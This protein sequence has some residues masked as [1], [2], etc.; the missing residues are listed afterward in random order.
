MAGL[1][2]T[3]SNM[4]E[5]L[6]ARL[7]DVISTPLTSP[8]SPE[9]V[10]INSR[11]MER[12]LSMQLADHHGICANMSFQFPRPFLLDLL[13][14]MAGAPGTPDLYHPDCLTWK[15]MKLL[16]DISSQP[17]FESIRHYL[18][19]D[20][21]GT[22]RKCYQISRRIARAFDQYL[23][24]RP[25]MI[26]NWESGR[27]HHEDETWQA[28]LWNALSADMAALHPVAL[29]ELFK[30]RIQGSDQ[31]IVSLPER[32]SLIGISALAPLFIDVLLGLSTRTDIHLFLFNPC[33]EYWSEVLSER[34]RERR[35]KHLQLSTDVPLTEVEE[36]LFLEKG[37]P[38]LASMG[39]IS[40]DFLF[41]LA[42]VPSQHQDFF[43]RPGETTLL[44]TVQSDILDLIDRSKGEAERLPL[45]ESDRSIECHS[46]HSPLREVE[47]LHDRLL[48]LFESIPQLKPR[49]ILVMTPDIDTYAPLI[50]SVF[51]RTDEETQKGIR[52]FIPF[53][54]ADR[55]HMRNNPVADT[56][57]EILD[58]AESRFEA[59]RVLTLLDSPMIRRAFFLSEEEIVLIR[60]WVEETGIRWGI[61]DRSLLDLELPLLS[62]HTWRHGID[63]MLLGYALPGE[64][65]RLFE[66]RLPYDG[67]EGEKT[68][69]LGRFIDLMDHLFTVCQHLLE[70]HSLKAWRAILNDVCS[71]FLRM[72]EDEEALFHHRHLIDTINDL[73]NAAE[74]GGYFDLL[75]LAV[76]RDHLTEQL[77]GAGFS[78]GFLSGGVTFCAMVPMRSVPFKVIALLG[79]NHAQFPRESAKIGFDLIERHRRRG[80][81]SKRDDDRYLFLETILS[82][83]ERLMIFYIGQSIRDNSLIPP[84]VVV[85][86]LLDYLG[87]SF[88][89]SPHTTRET[90]KQISSQED[91]EKHLLTIHPLQPFSPVYFS[92]DSRR[93]SYNGEYFR[94]ARSLMTHPEPQQTFVRSPLPADDKFS[95]NV[96]INDLLRFFRH[97]ARFFIEQSLG[98]QLK[99]ED[100]KSDDWEA[101]I[102]SGLSRYGVAQTMLD[103]RLDAVASGQEYLILSE[104]GEL[105]LGAVG[106][107][108]YQILASEIDHYTEQIRRLLP[109]SDREEFNVDLTL[110]DIHLTG[111]ISLPSPRGIFTYR[112][113]DLKGKD[114]LNTWLL[115]LYLSTASP[116]RPWRN[117]LAGRKDW[118][119]FQTPR[120]AKTIL[121]TMLN[122]YRKGLTRPLPFFPQASLMY[123]AAIASG[124]STIEALA[125]ARKVWQATDFSRG[126]EDDPYYRLCFGKIDPL[127]ETFRT[128]SEAVYTPLLMHRLVFADAETLLTEMA[129]IPS[130]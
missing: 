84:S 77:E 39:K 120:D 34:E 47:V 20:D 27:R 103:N 112:Y 10:L 90:G 100:E 62:P 69:V 31:P 107:N 41:A 57:F 111:R 108:D 48:S 52:A 79:M 30:K 101:F 116:E 81:R 13:Q 49:D 106:Q 32:I 18:G 23:V 35:L 15:I 74:A 1:H 61:D 104:M 51:E 118:V 124:K 76:I 50:E 93:F 67:I 92:D 80:D 19:P 105:P 38:L 85:S 29:Y 63:R 24:Y 129:V 121:M 9:I 75:P 55:R 37:N 60:R 40:R 73:S 98:I 26:L 59:S 127:D 119:L 65:K 113:A 44:R 2:I 96:A 110:C 87:Q 94:A 22:T 88:V 56:F 117:C 42:D 3:T 89:R 14:N 68:E 58:L 8:L 91:I 82:A 4:M 36:D 12:W 123:A 17:G 78:G 128:L 33:R 45:S 122:V 72:D 5:I 86:E 16:P 6:A 115:H 130:P 54:I 99:A 102:L 7:T 114:Y 125:A 11:G 43:V 95:A 83:R 25:D 66:K 53:S 71:R 46:C 64:N 70:K 97:P 21:E 109:D 126:E 28:A